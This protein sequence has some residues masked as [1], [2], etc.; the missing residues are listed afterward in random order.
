MCRGL[1]HDV[2]TRPFCVVQT[3][4]CADVDAQAEDEKERHGKSHLAF[5]RLAACLNQVALSDD[6][7]SA[8]DYDDSPNKRRRRSGRGPARA[9]GDG[10]GVN[11]STLRCPMCNHPEWA[12]IRNT[13]WWFTGPCVYALAEEEQTW[14]ARQPGAGQQMHAGFHPKRISS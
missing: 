13:A 3:F 14:I 4:D 10:E 2:L 12:S 9:Q 1:C 8:E 7:D 6:S 11:D 5:Q